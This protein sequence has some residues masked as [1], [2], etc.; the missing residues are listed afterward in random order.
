MKKKTIVSKPAKKKI[1]KKMPV[2]KAKKTVM[3]YASGA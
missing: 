1:A 3:G 2:K